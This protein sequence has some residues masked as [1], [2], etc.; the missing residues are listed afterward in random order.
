M[1]QE[2]EYVIKR[3]RKMYRISKIRFWRRMVRQPS[4]RQKMVQRLGKPQLLAIHAAID[5]T[6]KPQPSRQIDLPLN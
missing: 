6:L 1:S 3:R 5:Q 2:I 4:E